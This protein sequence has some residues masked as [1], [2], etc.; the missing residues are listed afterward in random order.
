MHNLF[1]ALLILFIVG[2]VLRMDWIYYLAYVIGGV[3]LFSHLSVRRS[4][5]N[6]T[7][8]RTFMD[9]TFVG[10]QIQV[11]LELTNRAWLPAPWIV[12]E[13]R[14]PLELRDISD[15]RVALSVSGRSTTLH[16]YTL[17]CKQRGYYRLGP[18]SLRTGDLF[19]FA[20]AVWEEQAPPSITIYP[21]VVSL[22]ELGLPSAI[23][24]G[25][26]A[27]PQKLYEDPA[28]LS[29]VRS[30]TNGDTLRR[31]HWKA[32]AHANE[33]LVKKFQPS[34]A[35]NMMV[36]LDLH[37]DHYPARYMVSASEW[38]IVVAASMAAYAVGQRQP[39]GLICN[40]QDAQYGGM[41]ATLVPRSGQAQ[42]MAILSALAR[43]QLNGAANDLTAWLPTPLAK[44][45]WGTVVVLVAPQIDEA[46]LWLLHQARRRGSTVIALLCSEQP[47]F[48]GM[49]ARAEKLGI[50][51][52]QSIWDKD[53]HSLAAAVAR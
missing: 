10:Q 28:R 38:A 23:P 49:R 21:R 35:L 13:E 24:F 30:Y 7:I 37:P 31:I 25:V 16:A 14:V 33:L 12:V 29:G 20:D 27:T 9:K 8:K 42:L 45:E 47:G 11:R 46:A 2:S 18:I 6:L 41:M 50:S 34:V 17:A 43:V 3:Y 53:L 19:G 15:Y 26:M 48:P 51:L 44:L 22:Q 39:V 52:H 36:I 1:W 4:L 40:G 32:S 5:G